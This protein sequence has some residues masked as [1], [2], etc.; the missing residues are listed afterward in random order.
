MN[1][2]EVRALIRPQLI[3]FFVVSG[4]CLVGLVIVAAAAL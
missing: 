1:D 4:L 2:D 3:R